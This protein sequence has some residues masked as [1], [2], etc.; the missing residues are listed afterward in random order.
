MKMVAPFHL[1]NRG[2]FLAVNVPVKLDEIQEKV[3]L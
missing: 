1:V 2:I 3:V